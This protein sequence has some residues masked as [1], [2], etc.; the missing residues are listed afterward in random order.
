MMAQI[1]QD[2]YNKNST[3]QDQGKVDP[4]DTLE[5]RI[6]FWFNIVNYDGGPKLDILHDYNLNNEGLDH[7]VFGSEKDPEIGG[8]KKILEILRCD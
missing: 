1:K 8:L 5:N 6:K 4:I 3:L 7:S 2:L